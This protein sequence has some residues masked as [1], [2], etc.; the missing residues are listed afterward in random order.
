M[1]CLLEHTSEITRVCVSQKYPTMATMVFSQC[2]H[3]RYDTIAHTLEVFRISL[4]CSRTSRVSRPRGRLLA[5]RRTPVAPLDHECI[6]CWLARPSLQ[7]QRRCTGVLSSLLAM[8]CCSSDTVQ[9]VRFSYV[10]QSEG[11]QRPLAPLSLPTSERLVL[12]DASL[13]SK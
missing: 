12:G 4:V 11:S 7:N 9:H 8:G 13:D 10:Q 3:L 6:K 1:Y 5:A 2:S